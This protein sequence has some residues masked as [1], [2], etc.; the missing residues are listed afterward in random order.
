MK[1]I[2]LLLI[3]FNA[4]S[5][6]PKWSYDPG[7]NPSDPMGKE[8]I[9]I[10]ANIPNMPSLSDKF[11]GRKQKFRPAF[12]PIP[13]RMRLDE[14]K[15]KILFMGQDGTHIAEAAGRPATAG[16]G[17]RAQD[18]AH[19]FGVD[20]G[21]AFINAYSFTI[22]G[23][24]GL[25]NTPFL[26]TGEEGI[27]YAHKTNFVSN[28]L[29]LL[30]HD[31]S[32]P[33]TKW[34]NNLIDWIIRNN[35][36]SMKLIVLFGGAARDAAASY[37]MSMGA[38]VEGRYEE[39]MKNISIPFIK[40]AYAGGNNTFPVVLNKEGKDLYQIKLGENLN[41]KNA[42]DQKKALDD[43]EKRTQDY[44]DDLALMLNGSYK[45]GLISS[46]QLGGF[47]LDTMTVNGIKTR[48]LKGLKLSDGTVI[49]NDIVIISLPHPSS[50][51]RT[52]IEADSYSVGKKR[53]SERVMRD[54]KVLKSFVK[55]G[56]EIEADPGKKNYF[57]AGENYEY[58]RTDIGPEF[59]DFGTPEN[60]MVSRS[61]ARRMSGNANVVI[62]GT[63]DNGKFSKSEIK[64]MTDAKAGNLINSENLF[65]A[66]P[67]VLDERYVFDAGPGESLAKIMIENLD[68]EKI[69]ETKTSMSF[70]NDGIDAYYVRNHPDVSDFGHY[71]GILKN[72][73][74]LIV[75]DPQ[76][77]DDI[78]TAR[79]LTGTRGQYLQS[80]MNHIGIDKNY[81]LLKTVPFA[82]DEASIHDWHRTFDLTKEYRHKIYD[83]YFATEKPKFI[84]ADG[85]Y[86]LKSIKA[87]LEKS[88]LSI[89]VY[90][91]RRSADYKTDLEDLHQIFITDGISR[92]RK[93]YKATLANIPRAHLT[94]YSRVW[95]GTSGDRVITSAG[96]E[97]K[98]I[99]FAE[100]VPKWAYTQNSK[101]SNKNEAQVR[102]MLENVKNLGL[103]L[104]YESIPSYFE[105]LAQ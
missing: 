78:I 5:K 10:T 68:L 67:R 88:N 28:E 61:T 23:Q 69:F 25:Y 35:K 57:A 3:S 80:L 46:A 44:K 32:S 16:F 81:F 82:M 102:L 1:L 101:L 36:K 94:F 12:G 55:N 13:W 17:G 56:W 90:S 64:K 38:K 2:I 47:D 97:Y 39:D 91:L 87:Y 42:K 74:V 22:K 11:M 6:M 50:L 77:Y 15:V 62:I 85:D 105:R 31:L 33:I 75:A 37:A 30:G 41:Y 14:N 21:A 4:Y 96:K 72:S 9:D 93:I 99:A 89:P 79:A 34:R 65:I 73:K 27:P 19:Y 26:W 58:G 59:Y 103:K 18:F 66:R 98:G 100:V 7:P 53:A 48:S 60:R 83:Y 63:R 20:E 49:E 40:S 51:S 43:I 24:Y 8:L 71:R 84:I 45:N 52:V 54:V 70:K 92:S 104:P 95:E 29:W 76:G 86:A